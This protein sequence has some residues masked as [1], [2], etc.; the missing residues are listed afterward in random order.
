[1]RVSIFGLG[2][3][4]TVC[5]GCLAKEGHNII[6]V[7]PV[8]AK[9]RLVN[10][11][12][13]P[14]I[15]ADIEEIIAEAVRSGRLRATE[16][17]IQAVSES[18]I[19][20]VC[21]GTPSQI[22]GNLDLTHVRSVCEQLGQALKEK[23]TRHTV[24]IRSTILPGTM[25][26]IVI[27]ILEENSGKKAGRDFGVCNNPEFLREGTAVMDF[28][29]PSKTVIGEVDSTSGDALVPL[30]AKLNAPLIRTDIETAEMVKYIDNSWHA[31]KIGFA[32]EIG[33]L[34]KSF[35]VDSHKAMEIF[36]QDK[37]LNISPAYLKPG[38]AFGGSCLPKDLRA[39]SYSAKLQDLELPILNA[40]LPS[41]ELQVS[42][43]L[44]LIMEKGRRRVGILGFSFKEGTDDL[45]ESPMIEI[46]ERLAGKGYDIRIY[47]RNVQI[48]RLVGANRDFILNRIPHISRLMVDDIDSVLQHAETIVIGN[49]SP[50]FESV[51]DRLK[52]GQCLVDFVRI[53]NSGSHNGEYSGICW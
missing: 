20:F 17:S 13:S 31:L 2:Y 5:S 35:S 25:R 16:D 18:D 44:K 27:P 24:V 32:N 41:N 43:G 19:S 23:S 39:L 30:Y 14:I 21:V 53:S 34:C 38:F 26:R 37:K 1:M 8:G 47:D 46:I 6:G 11:G 42:R 10:A 7:D 9:V 33:N 12:K 3:V 52:P 49:K 48:A 22:N 15:E 36:C 45:R 51:P 40:I 29:F 50:E 28:A 4:G